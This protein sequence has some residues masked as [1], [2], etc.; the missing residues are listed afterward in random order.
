MPRDA[1]HQRKQEP[2]C[3]QFQGRRGVLGDVV[4][5]W[6][7]GG[8]RDAQ[9]TMREML[10]EN[11]ILPPEWQIE[12]PFR[13]ERRDEHL[14]GGGNVAE[15]C[16]HRI[17]WHQIGNRENHKGRQQSNKQRDQQTRYDIAKHGRSGCT[18]TGWMPGPVRIAQRRRLHHAAGLTRASSAN[19]PAPVRTKSATLLRTATW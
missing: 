5:D 8:N 18:G 1:D 11:Q 7:L 10:E 4:H 12:S 16:Q 3:R 14:V 9:I 19:Q 6:P 15:L 13:T 17:A 2:A